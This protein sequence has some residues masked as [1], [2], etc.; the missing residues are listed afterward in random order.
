MQTSGT[1]AASQRYEVSKFFVNFIVTNFLSPGYNRTRGLDF[2][3]CVE[4][5]FYHSPF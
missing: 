1:H 4:Y 5:C 2:T 3:V